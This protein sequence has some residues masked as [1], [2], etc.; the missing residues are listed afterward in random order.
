MPLLHDLWSTKQP[1]SMHGDFVSHEDELGIDHVKNNE[2]GSEM[3]SVSPNENSL[4]PVTYNEKAR[5]G[6]RGFNVDR[7]MLIKKIK[8]EQSPNWLSSSN[9]R[10]ETEIF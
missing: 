4:S 7:G 6:S 3:C 2:D 8:R 10:P 1:G 9:V 5:M